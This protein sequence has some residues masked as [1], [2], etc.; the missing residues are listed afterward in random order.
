MAGLR[1]LKGRAAYPRSRGCV[2]RYGAMYPKWRGRYPVINLGLDIDTPRVDPTTPKINIPIN[3]RTLY[4]PS[5]EK[6]TG[7]IGMFTLHTGYPVMTLAA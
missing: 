2:P 7:P 3:Y 6:P 4:T 5:K 1:T